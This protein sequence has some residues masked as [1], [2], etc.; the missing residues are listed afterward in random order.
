VKLRLRP[1]R[2]GSSLVE[3]N[4]KPSPSHRG[5]NLRAVLADAAGERDA[6]TPPSSSMK[7]A[8]IM[9]NRAHK[10][11]QRQPRRLL[12]RRRGLVRSR[13]SPL[14][15]LIPPAPTGCRECAPSHPGRARASSS[16]A[17]RRRTSMSPTRLF[18]GRPDCG[19]APKLVSMATPSRKAATLELP[20]RW[21]EM[22]RRILA[23]QQRLGSLAGRAMAG[24]VESIAANAKLRAPLVRHRVGGRRLV[25][26]CGRDRSRSPRPAARR[27]APGERP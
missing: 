10:H 13:R 24:A 11:I 22:W 20:P 18:C 15:P 25:H 19:D 4:P 8:Q 1:C 3:F 9:A 21:Q 26:E 17:A 5:A 14:V 2:R 27:E 23:A 6:S 16:C 12:A 7:R